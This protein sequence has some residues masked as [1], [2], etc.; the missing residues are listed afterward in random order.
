MSDKNYN[1]I[2]VND[3]TFIAYMYL[4]S[5]THIISLLYVLFIIMSYDGRVGCAVLTGLETRRLD[6]C[7]AC[8]LCG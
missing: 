4:Y 3:A 5:C 8:A 7:V 6:C 1:V 2:Y